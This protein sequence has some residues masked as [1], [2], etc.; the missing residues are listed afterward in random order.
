ML[1]PAIAFI[2]F[3]VSI[4]VFGDSGFIILLPLTIALARRAGM[5]LSG[6][7]VALAL[8]LTTSHTMVPP[9]PGPIAAAGILDADL[10]MVILM[11]LVVSVF[12]LIAC[13]TFAT[14]IGR[15]YPIE[16]PESEPQPVNTTF[17]RPPA[18]KAFIPILVPI[19]LIVGKSIAEYPSAPLGTG[20][21]QRYLIFVGSPT[22][23]LLLGFILSWILPQRFDAKLLSATGWLGKGL[24]DAAVIIIITGAGGAFGNII[25]QSEL[26]DVLA[27]LLKDVS[28]GIFLPFLLAATLKTAQGSSTVALITTASIMV[29]LIDPLGL[30]GQMDRALTVL[31]IG[32]GAA[33]FSH[34]NDSFFWIFTQMTGLNVA[35]GYRL[36]SLGTFILGCSAISVIFILKL[37]I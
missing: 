11:G 20:A 15:T 27:D 4:P 21:L 5:S 13:V 34:A 17:Y 26:A 16:V 31:A 9:T 28:I 24:R 10:G 29:P 8:G 19:L 7:I 12:V 25:Q 37:L 23:A 3:I 32:A 14:Y 18:W 33:V 1:I 36:Q 35:Q 22:I 2:G 30:G 6:P